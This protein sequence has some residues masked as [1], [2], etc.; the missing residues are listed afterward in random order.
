M[1]SIRRSL[2]GYLLLLLAIALSAVGLLV[3]RFANG[4]IRQREAS[5]ADRIEQTFK[6]RQSEVKT[7]FDADVMNETKA[8][9]KDVHYKI[10]DLLGQKLDQRKGSGGPG[11]PPRPPEPQ[12]P[13]KAPDE[14]AKLFRVRVAALGLAA[15]P[16]V[17]PVPLTVAMFEPRVPNN[18]NDM[19][20]PRVYNDPRRYNPAPN[21][22]DYDAPRFVSRVQEA[23]RRAYEDEDHRSQFQFTIVATYYPNRPG[24]HRTV[25]VIHSAKLGAE[26]PLDPAWLEQTQDLEPKTDDP[27]VPGQGKLHRVVTTAG[28]Y[29]S[30]IRF[31]VFLPA[32]PA[33]PVP[34]TPAPANAAIRY[35][36]YPPFRGVDVALRVFVH[37]PR[38][39]SELDAR[40]A[41]LQK[42][43]D[44][45]VTR[46]REETRMELAQL[47]S[48]LIIIGTGTF[49]AL[50]LG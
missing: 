29:G 47:R 34:A 44:E 49:A 1:R 4:A 43:R 22:S 35:P 9:A 28:V 20:E 10:A 3:D 48:R 2:L 46:V 19:R 7:K 36:A 38:P 27:E 25:A 6:L 37:H 40:L 21:W 30:P 8:L 24:T 45:Q 11:G 18:P 16:V 41:A 42:E 50:V 32:L 26:L 15:P 39:Y 23:L 14:E 17:A 13:V 33:P 5:E 31:F 12:P